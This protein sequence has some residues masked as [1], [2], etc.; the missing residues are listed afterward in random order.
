MCIR[1]R[2]GIKSVGANYDEQE[3]ADVVTALKARTRD[4]K[5]YPL[6]FV[7]NCNYGFQ[8]NLLAMRPVGLLVCALSVV[9]LI[10]LAV[11]RSAL[12]L[13]IEV[14]DLTA[15]FFGLILLTAMWFFVPSSSRV[16]GAADHYA[17]RLLETIMGLEP[18]PPDA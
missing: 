13:E 18:L 5:R 1:D 15:G 12:D 17:E 2:T 4:A 10:A 8:R 14:F 16:R 6:V 9:V 3:A 11:L 7:E